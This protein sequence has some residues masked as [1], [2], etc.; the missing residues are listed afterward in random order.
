MARGEDEPVMADALIVP[1][2]TEPYAANGLG[3]FREVLSRARNGHEV[4]A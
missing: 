1:A 2:G 3:G 4:S